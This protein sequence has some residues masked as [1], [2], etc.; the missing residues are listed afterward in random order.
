MRSMT[1]CF[2]STLYR[3]TLFRFWPLW[4]LYG[5][6]WLFVLPLRLLNDYFDMLRWDSTL[7]EAQQWLAERCYHIPETLI[8]GVWASAFFGVL[9][10]MA[11]FSYLYNNRSACMM[12][13]LP[14]RREGLFTTQYLAGLSFFL[15]PHL[16]VSILTAALELTLIPSEQWY[17]IFPSLGVWLL[18]QS[19]TCLFFFS[20]AV[21]CAMFTGHILALPA[22]YG[23]L[24]ALV[25]VIYSLVVEL[26]SR[27]FYGFPSVG[28]GN[29]LN[30]PLVR[31]CT[32]LFTLTEACSWNVGQV[33][34]NG[35]TMTTDT[36]YL[37]SPVMVAGYAA[38]GV[39]LT[40][41]A[42]LIYRVRHVESAGDVISIPIVRPFFQCGVALCSG[43]CLG[44]LTATFFNWSWSSLPLSVCVMIW[45]CL[46]WF[47]AEMLLKK[48]F[49]VFSAWRGGLVI[50]ALVGLL[51]LSFFLDLFGVVERVPQADDV[52]S[53]S[54]SGS[55]SYPNDS[56]DMYLTDITDPEILQQFIDL[57]YA[58]VQARDRSNYNTVTYEPG[59]NYLS[60]SLTYTLNNGSTLTRRYSSVPIF[61]GETELLGSVTWC[62][63]QLVDNRDLV[64]QCYGFDRL[65]EGRLVEAYLYNALDNQGNYSTDLY[66]EGVTQEDLQ[67]LWQAV[68][69]DFDAGTI[70]VRYLFSDEE[71]QKNTLVTDLVFVFELPAPTL[72]NPNRT[73]TNELSITL[74]PNATYTMAWLEEHN[75]PG[76][77]Y[78]L[79][80]H[81]F[82]VASADFP[83][84]YEDPYEREIHA[85]SGAALPNTVNQEVE[86]ATTPEDTSALSPENS[87]DTSASHSVPAA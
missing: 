61:Q 38:A 84:T 65:E 59:D 63:K 29:P 2:N 76:D 81:D 27:F 49:R 43:L 58:I 48:S 15:L 32:P 71:R 55:M 77:G 20:F 51:C 85:V 25:L 44:V 6:L 72:R 69:A 33:M 23:I 13:A 10:A 53:L 62:A 54:V 37:N 8:F 47:V 67:Q 14:L 42:L 30:L 17:R 22:F 73:T 57:H 28:Y 21:F 26:M 3:K 36:W 68:R 34:A 31:W 1:S 74:S 24:N 7:T 18:V 50:T 45:T 46:G 35:Y 52:A 56:G 39:V 16:V 70:G 78:S 80:Y 9:A 86:Q 82:E 60:L 75:L 12:H 83:Y 4:G 11:C 79:Q 64:E 5:L 66:L 40:V 87:T 19:A 41:L